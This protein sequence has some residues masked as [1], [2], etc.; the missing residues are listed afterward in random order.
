M[1]CQTRKKALCMLARRAANAPSACS[2]RRSARSCRGRGSPAA[3]KARQPWPR[4]SDRQHGCVPFSRCPATECRRFRRNA[5]GRTPGAAAAAP[6]APRIPTAPAPATP[7][8]RGV[9][10]TQ[11]GPAAQCRVSAAWGY[12]RI[13]SEAPLRGPSVPRRSAAQGPRCEAVQRTISSCAGSGS[14]CGDGGVSSSEKALRRRA[15]A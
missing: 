7:G 11:R 2:R 14:R 4:R 6:R 1:A 15:V 8:T 9:L 3:R 10:P 12:T 13:A 5:P